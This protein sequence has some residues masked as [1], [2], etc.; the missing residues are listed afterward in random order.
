MSPDEV[1]AFRANPFHAEAVRLRRYDEEAKDP[2][3]NT[4]DF[5]YYLRHVPA[6]KLSSRA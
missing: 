6:C 3:A 2:R 4:P 5:D 1:E